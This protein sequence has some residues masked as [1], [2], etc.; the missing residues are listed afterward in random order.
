MSP[1]SFQS[2]QVLAVDDDDLSLGLVVK[3]CTDLGVA[4]TVVA[5]TGSEALS[6]LLATSRPFD[7]ILCDLKMPNGNGFQLLK[8]LRCGQIRSARPDTCFIFMTG[9][10]D[11]PSVQAAAQLDA[12]GYLV[13]PVTIEKLRAAFTRAKGK[14]FQVNFAKYAETAV[15]EHVG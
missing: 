9:I 5:R 6:A 8:M 3:L 14:T 1:L 7:F 2:F 11:T 12:N 4:K 13:K 15:P 10:C